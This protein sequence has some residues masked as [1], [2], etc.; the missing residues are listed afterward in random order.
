[1]YRIVLHS[2]YLP[3]CFPV[4]LSIDLLVYKPF[5]T[6]PINPLYPLFPLF[7]LSPLSPLAPL[8]PLFP[9]ALP[10]VVFLYYFLVME[11][12][13]TF[14]L[15]MHNLKSDNDAYFRFHILYFIF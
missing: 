2:T 7:P 6:F 15:N 4:Y 12:E 13:D 8:C 1:M 9:P 14:Q 10:E 5:T 11:N 3:V